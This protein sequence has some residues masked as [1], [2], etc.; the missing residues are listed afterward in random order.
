MGEVLI[1][2]ISRWVKLKLFQLYLYRLNEIHGFYI[3]NVFCWTS[4]RGIPCIFLIILVWFI[5]WV[6]SVIEMPLCWVVILNTMSRYRP[7]HA[8]TSS[9]WSMHQPWVTDPSWS[10]HQHRVIDPCINLEILNHPDPC[11][12]IELLNHPY[13]SVIIELLIHPDPWIKL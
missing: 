13:Q 2:L 6:V 1:R 11:V 9:Y 8:S 4:C 5:G 12:H 10:M 7:I 3:R